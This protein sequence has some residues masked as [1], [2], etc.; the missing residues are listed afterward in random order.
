MLEDPKWGIQG[1][2]LPDGNTTTSQMFAD[3]ANLLIQGSEQNLDTA[4]Q[5]LN[6][7]CQ[8]SGAAINWKKIVGIWVSRRPRD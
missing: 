1:F 6:C 3:N 8:G 2:R 4:I 7:F 5:V